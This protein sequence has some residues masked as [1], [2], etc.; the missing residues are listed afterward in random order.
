MP[1]NCSTLNPHCVSP[2]IN[3]QCTGLILLNTHS[4]KAVNTSH[5]HTH[6]LKH[7]HTLKAVNGSRQAL[8]CCLPRQPLALAIKVAIRVTST[9]EN[10]AEWGA[11]KNLPSP[12]Y[13]C[14]KWPPRIGPI[15]P[16]E[17]GGPYRTHSS[18]VGQMECRDG[19]GRDGCV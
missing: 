2:P 1:Q 6:T 4:Y 11:V 12:L 18:W 13:S 7:Q 19:I 8:L 16:H 3:T 15:K 17:G 10:Q 9:V 5:T 14:S